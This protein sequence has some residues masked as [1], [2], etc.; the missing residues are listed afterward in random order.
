[1]K[2]LY[3]E[4]D[5]LQYKNLEDFISHLKQ[6]IKI[7]ISTNENKDNN[8][9]VFQLIFITSKMTDH[10]NLIYPYDLEECPIIKETCIN[11][12]SQKENYAVFFIHDITKCDYI[13][14]F[15]KK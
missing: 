11:L 15:Y 4:L 10:I 9:G 13:K 2:P 1:M 5:L 8:K 6:I 7:Y 14:P 3:A 12:I